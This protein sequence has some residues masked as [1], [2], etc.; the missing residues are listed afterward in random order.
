[1]SLAVGPHPISVNVNHDRAFACRLA[2]A[3]CD[4]KGLHLDHLLPSL[5][6]RNAKK[7]TLRYVR[8]I[9]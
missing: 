2:G 4:V 9:A 1:M 3:K 6:R 5:L 7:P 8:E